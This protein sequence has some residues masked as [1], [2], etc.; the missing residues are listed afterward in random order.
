MSKHNFKLAFEVIDLIQQ[1]GFQAYIVGGA[2]RDHLLKQPI[3][4]ID[5][6][7]SATPK[8]IQ[9]MFD[10][11]IP[12]GIE[13]GTVIVRYSK[14]SFEVTTFRSEEG[15]SDFRHPD[16]VKF[17]DSID[18]DL[19][20]RDFTIN[21]IAMTKEGLF[22]DPFDGQVDLNNR[23]IRAVGHPVQ[24]FTEDPLRILRAIRFVS[25]LN[26]VLDHLTWQ[27]IKANVELIEKLS[28]ERVTIELEKLFSGQAV[29]MAVE[30][31]NKAQLLRYLPIFKDHKQAAVPLLLI[32]KPFEHIIDVFCY[33]YLSTDSPTTINQWCKAY[34]LANKELR[35]GELLIE[36]IDL[37]EKEGL[38]HWLVYQLPETLIH[39]FIQLVDQILNYTITKK[40]ISKIQRQ[41]PIKNR[42]EIAFNGRD[43]LA[44]YPN[45]PKGEWIRF[46]LQDIERN[47][48]ENKLNN[49]YHQIK[50]W[51]LSCH[52]P[53]KN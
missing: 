26:F 45:R 4:D 33:L 48:I 15:Y 16:Q 13:H 28:I 10:Q 22:V 11:V 32:K 19:S 37:Y 38:T 29:Q 9:M 34:R 52:P 50:E 44:F 53:E 21:A 3:N 27:D 49:D 51:I 46:Y 20:R 2:V 6:A 14:V 18:T 8:E 24:R 43:L 40:E 17:V 31:I 35:K 12:V 36:L 7:T 42:K 5:I 30:Y 1:A 41:L 23:L 47:I 25:Q 39:S